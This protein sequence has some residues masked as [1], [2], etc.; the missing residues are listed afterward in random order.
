M[1]KFV[2]GKPKSNSEEWHNAPALGLG[3]SLETGNEGDDVA[4]LRTGVDQVVEEVGVGGTRDILKQ[5]VFGVG[6]REGSNSEIVAPSPLADVPGWLDHDFADGIVAGKMCDGRVHLFLRVLARALQVQP[7]DL[8]DS[9][10]IKN[11]KPYN[12]EAFDQGDL[13]VLP[14]AI[15]H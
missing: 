15:D 8:Y 11:G 10:G 9:L 13:A 3:D 1:L 2:R 4:E 12:A 6:E 7:F 14:T 5:D